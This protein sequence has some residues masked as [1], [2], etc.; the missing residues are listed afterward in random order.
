M[1]N[2]QVSNTLTT[3]STVQPN[4]LQQYIQED[5]SAVNRRRSSVPSPFYRMDTQNGTAIQPVRHQQQYIQYSDGR[6]ASLTHL[7]FHSPVPRQATDYLS[8]LSPTRSESFSPSEAGSAHPE[9]SPQRVSFPRPR[10]PSD[11]SSRSGSNPVPVTRPNS[12]PQSLSQIYD[13]FFPPSINPSQPPILAPYAQPPWNV[14]GTSPTGY[15]HT[16]PPSSG[17]SFPEPQHLAQPT[18]PKRKRETQTSPSPQPH[19]SKRKKVLPAEEQPV[20]S[21]SRVTLDTPS[22][23]SAP[24]FVG[25]RRLICTKAPESPGC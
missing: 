24:S 9:S 11:R 5:I 21:S 12:H 18:R 13:P 8:A 23:V 25:Y 19:R 10:V 14:G 17:P 22:D 1:A 20:A 6:R 16:S 3:A 2:D 7:N 15:I 4:G